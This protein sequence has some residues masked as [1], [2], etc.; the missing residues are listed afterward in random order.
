MLTEQQI[1]ER[2]NGIGGT[3]VAAILGISPYLTPYQLWEIKTGRAEPKQILTEDKLRIRHAHEI[4]IANEFA[5]RHKVELKTVPETLRHPE[6]PFLFCHLDRVIIGQ[7][8]I[9]E[10]K[11]SVSYLSRLWGESGTTEAPPYYR[12]QAHF[13]MLVTGYEKVIIAALIDTDDYR[14]FPILRDE[15]IIKAMKE[16]CVHFW[17]HHV[18]G[19][20]PPPFTNREDVELA[21]PFTKPNLKEADPEIRDVYQKAQFK[22]AQIKL[23]EEEKE[24]LCDR[25]AISIGEAEG[26]AENGEPLLT[27]KPRKDGKRVMRFLENRI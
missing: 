2:K 18:I 10:C 14:E 26:L 25:L 17:N 21:Y 23:L 27:Y 8:I 5:Y 9:V 19:D 7:N 6:Y 22:R 1:A 11:S 24:K 4:T 12:A 16:K 13:Q 15:R 20:V 3:D